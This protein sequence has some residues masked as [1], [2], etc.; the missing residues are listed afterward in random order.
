MLVWLLFFALILLVVYMATGIASFLVHFHVQRWLAQNKT[1]IHEYRIN[2]DLTPAEFGYLFDRRLRDNELLATLVFMKQ[3]SAVQIS[4]IDDDLLL[5]V[6]N[7][8]IDNREL[9]MFELEL[10][11]NIKEQG[12]TISWKELSRTINSGNE[13]YQRLDCQVRHSLEQKGYFRLGVLTQTN[14]YLKYLHYALSA[15]ISLIFVWYPLRQAFGYSEVA[16]GAGFSAVDQL[17]MSVISLVVALMLWPIWYKYV[18]LLKDI[19]SYNA[20]IPYG[21]TDRLRNE[22]RIIYG[23][24]IFLQTVEKERL[25]VDP[26]INDKALPWCLAVD[27]GPSVGELR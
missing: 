5:S 3:S 17:I 22:W 6:E 11:A 15:T 8:A 13:I 20:G 26:N 1:L 16:L 12:G 25:M 9:D 23:Y 10:R 7:L 14:I 4:I 24:R 27:T 18:E 19:V 2:S 21:A